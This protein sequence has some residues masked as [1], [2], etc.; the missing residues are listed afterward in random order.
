MLENSNE[1]Q[2]FIARWLQGRRGFMQNFAAWLGYGNRVDEPPFLTFEDD[3]QLA[4]Y[5]QEQANYNNLHVELVDGVCSCGLVLQYPGIPLQAQAGHI[6]EDEPVSIFLFET[7]DGIKQQCQECLFEW[8]AFS[9]D[10]LHGARDSGAQCH[11]CMHDAVERARKKGC[12][13]HKLWQATP[14][15]FSQILT[16]AKPGVTVYM[17]LLGA[18]LFTEFVIFDKFFPHLYGELPK[19]WILMA[20][21]GL[22][23]WLLSIYIDG[24]AEKSAKLKAR[25][26]GT[27]MWA[28][29]ALVMPWVITELEGIMAFVW[30]V[31]GFN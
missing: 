3:M 26:V 19:I 4:L 2:G 8:P 24:D 6:W 31:L 27:F 14:T 18:Y 11:Y 28:G 5:D 22:V 25:A 13:V 15:V 7:P 12:R 30:K 9:N 10:C 21:V 23:I 29:Y 20:A 16:L 17:W 1:K